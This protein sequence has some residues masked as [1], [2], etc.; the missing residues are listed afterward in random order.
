MVG[1]PAGAAFQP[2]GH[3]VQEMTFA[4]PE[5]RRQHLRH[6]L[7][8]EHDHP[9]PAQ[10]DRQGGEDQEVRQVVD[11]DHGVPPAQGEREDDGKRRHEEEEVL[12][13]VA[14]H[15]LAAV[16]QR[17]L[18][19]AKRWMF[20]RPARHVAAGHADQVDLGALG[21]ELLHIAPDDRVVGIGVLSD[22]QHRLP[23]G[24]PKLG[25]TMHDLLHGPDRLPS[26]LVHSRAEIAASRRELVAGDERALE[27]SR[28]GLGIRGAEERRGPEVRAIAWCIE[29][30]ERPGEPDGFA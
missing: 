25:S 27:R 18:V 4:Q 30:H 21:E 20:R 6:Q 22:V 10:P 14:G 15:R 29:Q 13:Q 11:L 8:E 2:G 9:R 1:E 28:H 26:V 5:S 7:V 17:D 3:D 23:R 24:R 16:V 12:E 19:Q